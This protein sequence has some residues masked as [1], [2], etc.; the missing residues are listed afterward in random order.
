VA[1]LADGT[2]VKH[3]DEVWYRL[4]LDAKESWKKIALKRSGGAGLISDAKYTLYPEALPLD[5]KK[6]TKIETAH[7]CR[8]GDVN[9]C[10]FSLQVK[11]LAKFKAWIPKEFH[12]LYPDPPAAVRKRKRHDDEDEGDEEDEDGEDDDEAEAEED[13]DGNSREDGQ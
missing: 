5:P 7:G 11:D 4:S 9:T 10:L 12:S 3:P 8:R 2:L 13:D 6:V 1:E